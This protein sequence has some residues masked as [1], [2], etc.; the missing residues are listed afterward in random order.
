MRTNL[1]LPDA[2]IAIQGITGKEGTRMAE[3]LLGS[4]MRVVGGVTPGKG[5]QDVMGK[6]V[7]NTVAELRAAFPDV[8]ATCVTVP[9]ERVLGAAREAMESGIP[10]VHVLA[11]RVPVHDVLAMRALAQSTGATLL[12]PSSVGYL[13][14]PKFRLG[15][16]GGAQPFDAIAEGDVAVLSTSGGMANELTM[17]LGRA[18]IGIRLALAVGGDRVSGLSLLEAIRWAESLPDVR[19]L[20]IFIE[21]GQPLLPLLASGAETLRKPSVM[22]LAGDAL[23]ALPRGLPYGHTGTILGEEDASVRDLRAKLEARGMRVTGTVRD[24]VLSCNHL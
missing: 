8:A 17:A 5:G 23:D 19:R 12:G 6:P 7:F 3:W 1:F 14:F 9:P 10:F 22:F 4:G 13:Q 20:A 11:E 18:G 21:P 24:F 15:Y 2:A 16:L